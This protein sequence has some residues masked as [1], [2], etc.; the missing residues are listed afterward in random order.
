MIFDQSGSISNHLSWHHSPISWVLSCP[1]S[2]S[3]NDQ[4]IS[5]IQWTNSWDL[6][7][8]RSGSTS[9]KKFRE[10]N[11]LI[12]EFWVVQGL[13][14][15][16][17]NECYEMIYLTNSWILICPSTKSTSSEKNSWNQLTTLMIFELTKVWINLIRKFDALTLFKL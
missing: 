3:T 9:N 13:D 8:P 11:D 5:W 17:I 1:R 2:G 12:H 7:C 15:P 14:Q 16:L 10:F 6:I 4:I